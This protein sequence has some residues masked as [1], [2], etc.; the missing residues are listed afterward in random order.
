VKPG[1]WRQEAWYGLISQGKLWGIGQGCGDAV[2]L[3][4]KVNN[5]MREG[6]GAIE[7]KSQAHY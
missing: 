7:M 5:Q 3:S 4:N 6:T 2:M 1:A